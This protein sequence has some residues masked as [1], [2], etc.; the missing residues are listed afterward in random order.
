MNDP[1]LTRRRVSKMFIIFIFHHRALL[2]SS[3]SFL[4]WPRGRDLATLLTLKRRG[5]TVGEAERAFRIFHC[6]F[7]C[8]LLEGFQFYLINSLSFSVFILLF[9]HF[10]S[11]LLFHLASALLDIFL[12]FLYSFYESIQEFSVLPHIFVCLA[13]VLLIFIFLYLPFSFPLLPLLLHIA[14]GWL[15]QC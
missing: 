8:S 9:I 11:C 12:L 14:L 2:L 3:Y 15:F 4:L 7:I 10:Y 1:L 5:T 13:F 6:S